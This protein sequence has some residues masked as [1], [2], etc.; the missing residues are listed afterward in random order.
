M[1]AEP[2][3]DVAII[4][5]I[6]S[7]RGGSNK[8]YKQRVLIM[9]LIGRHWIILMCKWKLIG[10]MRRKNIGHKKRARKM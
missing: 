2:K 7:G 9:P 5:Q 6:S 1:V 8:R 3:K 4:E 10:K